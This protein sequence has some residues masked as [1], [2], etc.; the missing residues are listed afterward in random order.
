MDDGVK[1][2]RT[3]RSPG[4]D[5]QAQRTRTA[6]VRA[7]HALFTANGYGSTTLQQIADDAGVSVQTVYGVFGNKP[8]LLKAALDVA[9]AGDDRPVTVNERD[10]MHAVLNDPDP[11]TR[12]RAYA[13]AVRRIH[14]GAADMFV[15]LAAA[16]AADPALR[17]LSDETESRR[18]AGASSVVAGLASMGALR[19]DLRRSTAVDI[20]WTLNSADVFVLLVRRSGWNLGQYE[21]WL[22]ATL[23]QQLI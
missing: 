5:A 13:A 3:Y 18:R 20:V 15:A 8:A 12:L 2:D 21:E 7:A 11:S 6:V 17:G 19:A 22:G 16:A 4:R 9:I 10:W 14:V 23:V 1:I